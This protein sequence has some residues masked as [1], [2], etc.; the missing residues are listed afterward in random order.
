MSFCQLK[1]DL[2]V[3]FM[4]FFL[5]TMR[6]FNELCGNQSSFRG[7]V[8]DYVAAAARANRCRAELHAP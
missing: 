6:Q 1:S 5:L 4:G 8:K 3:Y 2:F 7:V